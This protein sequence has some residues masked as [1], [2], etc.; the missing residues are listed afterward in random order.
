M[1]CRFIF[2]MLSLFLTACFDDKVIPDKL[3]E[4]C[5]GQYYS[6]KIEIL[7]GHVIDST[8]SS[9]ISDANF[10]L[11][12]RIY[13][14]GKQDV[15]IYNNPLFHEDYNILSLTGTPSNTSPIKVDISYDIYKHMFSFFEPSDGYKKIYVINV[16]TCN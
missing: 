3:P 15:D 10:K 7:N 4:A 2:L 8:F 16:K 13:N 12:P 9:N 6:Q 1:V 14:N 11:S 5:L